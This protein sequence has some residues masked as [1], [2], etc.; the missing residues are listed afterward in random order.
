MGAVHL[1]DQYSLRA[2]REPP[3]QEVK[4]LFTGLYLPAYPVLEQRRSQVD[5]ERGGGGLVQVVR[6]RSQ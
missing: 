5:G 3:Q 4:L 6:N 2:A 1:G